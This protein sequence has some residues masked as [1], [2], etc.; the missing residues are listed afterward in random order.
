MSPVRPERLATQKSPSSSISTFANPHHNTHNNPP[1]NGRNNGSKVEVTSSFYNLLHRISNFTHD[2]WSTVLNKT[3]PQNIITA[4]AN[5]NVD[6]N[7]ANA[8]KCEEEGLLNCALSEDKLEAYKTPLGKPPKKQTRQ[9]GLGE[10][11]NSISPSLP[12]RTEQMYKF[13]EKHKKLSQKP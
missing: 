8:D 7:A 13:F 2:L 5:R 10:G 11:K 9:A 4:T 12:P 1:I 3:N 6:H